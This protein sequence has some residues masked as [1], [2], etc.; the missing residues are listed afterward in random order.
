MLEEVAKSHWTSLL[1]SLGSNFLTGHFLHDLRTQR[2]HLHCHRPLARIGEFIIVI[3]NF[4][5]SSQVGLIGGYFHAMDRLFYQLTGAGHC[6][7]NLL[8]VTSV[9]FK[10]RFFVFCMDKII[11]NFIHTTVYKNF[12]INEYNNFLHDERKLRQV[13]LIMIP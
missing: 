11:L 10:K 6:S 3:F 8:Q 1:F 13:T 9:L 7:S 4:Q 5:I 2:R 12:H